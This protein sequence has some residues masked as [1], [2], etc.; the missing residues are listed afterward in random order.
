M[1]QTISILRNGF[2]EPDQIDADVEGC[3]AIHETVPIID[4]E[5]SWT[6]THV[7]T[8][9][10]FLSFPL[11]GQALACRAEL[12]AG[13]LD[14]AAVTSPKDLSPAHKAVGKAMRAKYNAEAL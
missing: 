5:P 10:V 14:W 12:L 8:G 7:P 3:F 9:Y 1:Q 4:D 2:S 6:L 11:H 13:A